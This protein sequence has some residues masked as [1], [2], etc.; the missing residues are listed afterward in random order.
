MGNLTVVSGSVETWGNA[1][2][3]GLY[4]DQHPKLVNNVVIAAMGDSGSTPD[5]STQHVPAY[6][7]SY[8]MWQG[9][10]W[11]KDL[12]HKPDVMNADKQ[13]PGAG[14]IV[15]QGKEALALI[16]WRNW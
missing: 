16:E 6:E 8:S 14:K 3:S 1:K 12:A 11:N 7:K 2:G 9:K 4:F 13:Y 5:P 15:T 10:S